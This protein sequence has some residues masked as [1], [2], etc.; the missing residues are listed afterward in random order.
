MQK[1]RVGIAPYIGDY[2]D[3][4]TWLMLE[5]EHNPKGK[6][7]FIVTPLIRLFKDVYMLEAGVS[8]NEDILLNAV[9]RF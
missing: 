4:H 5:V 1:G 8:S 2:G 3:T 7:E 6:E 9:I